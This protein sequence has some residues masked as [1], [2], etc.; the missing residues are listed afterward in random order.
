MLN[1][2]SVHELNSRMKNQEEVVLIDC[3]EVSEFQS[4]HIKNSINYPLSTLQSKLHELEQ[5]K[6][7]EMVLICLSGARSAN[8]TL[9]LN[10]QGYTKAYN[11]Q[12]GVVTW[13]REGH[14]MVSPQQEN[15]HGL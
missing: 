1:Q 8:L 4:G 14:P 5:Y 15:D 12:G 9:F 7:R 2:M 11:L 13:M 10:G 3:R 6:D